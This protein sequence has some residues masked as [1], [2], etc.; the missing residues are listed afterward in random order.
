MNTIMVL[1]IF[2][3]RICNISL[4]KELSREG[5]AGERRHRIGLMLKD[6]M[7][8]GEIIDMTVARANRVVHEIESDLASQPVRSIG[9]LDDIHDM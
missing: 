8:G 4:D 6:L 5:F 7:H 2:C 1:S 3:T 9:E